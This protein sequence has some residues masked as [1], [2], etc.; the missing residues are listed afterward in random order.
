[1]EPLLA[2]YAGFS[3]DIF[4][5]GALGGTSYPEDQMQS[6]LQS[7]LDEL[8]YCMG[9]TT[10]YYGNLR[11]QHGHPEPFA[12]NYVELG[13]EDWFSGTYPYRFPILYDGIKAKYPN[14]TLISTAFDE[15]AKSFNYTIDIP[16]GGAW[17]THH[18]E[19]PS[20]FLES[21][22]FFDNW[23]E[24]TDNQDVTVLIGEYSV[25]QIDTPSGVVNFSNPANIHI[26]YPRLL[27]A[28]AESVYLLGAERNP[29]VV[30]W[31]SYA[32]SFENLNKPNWTP[33]LVA[34]T[35]DPADTTKSVSW[36]SQ[37]LLAHYHGTETL[38][39]T[40]TKGDFNPLW[41]VATIDESDT[42]YLKVVNSGNTSVPLT[43]DLDVPYSSAN[44]TILV[45]I[46]SDMFLVAF[47]TW[48]QTNPDVNAYNFINNETAVVPVSF[49]APASTRIGN[50]SF[51]WPVPAFS[52]TV[53]QF[54][55]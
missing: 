24:R 30:K 17:D 38:P 16:A 54:D 25:Y 23:Q 33:D 36:Y 14:I 10:T 50:G 9:D 7:A 42:I 37:S 11:A 46:L 41:W 6:V 26:S 2:I 28:I 31:T 34:F 12:I 53:L 19:E 8:E 22:N 18:Y 40:N 44:G 21:F 29:N 15:A 49:E 27:S 32:P 4:G 3:L 20:F 1:M 47:L 5:Y 52:I 13:N 39:V 55:I 51:A 43:V 35:A 48:P 45:R